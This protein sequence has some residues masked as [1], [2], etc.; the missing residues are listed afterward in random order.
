[1][2]A[3]PLAPTPDTSSRNFDLYKLAVE[4]YRFQ[5]RLNWERQE[6]ISY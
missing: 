2:G 6:T 4:E 1:M 5:V 3:Q